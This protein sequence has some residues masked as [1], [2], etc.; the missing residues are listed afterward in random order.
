MELVVQ[1]YLPQ[2]IQSKGATLAELG[3]LE[4]LD[5]ADQH[6]HP[7]DSLKFQY[8]V[9]IQQVTPICCGGGCDS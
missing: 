7:S 9:W 1:V 2:Y 5:S 8:R 6:R 3:Y 4:E